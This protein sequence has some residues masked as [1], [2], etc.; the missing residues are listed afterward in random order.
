[1]CILWIG[2]V[3]RCVW[4]W[5]SFHIQWKRWRKCI[6]LL[7]HKLSCVFVPKNVLQVSCVFLVCTHT[8]THTV[9][10]INFVFWKLC[11]ANMTA[12]LHCIIYMYTIIIYLYSC[13][14]MDIFPKTNFYKHLKC[15]YTLPECML[16]H[17]AVIYFCFLIHFVYLYYW[18]LMCVMKE[19]ILHF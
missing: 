7:L 8:H 10:T 19:L 12:Y 4:E 16:T 2:Q 14:S 6:I 9:M 18:L 5:H 1:M 3:S 13:S 11:V 15:V 17:T